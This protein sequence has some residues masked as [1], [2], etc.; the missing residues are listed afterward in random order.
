LSSNLGF[1]WDH[2]LFKEYCQ[3]LDIRTFAYFGKIDNEVL[4]DSLFYDKLFENRRYGIIYHKHSDFKDDEFVLRNSWENLLLNE[5]II[6]D[7]FFLNGG[8]WL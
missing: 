5:N 1:E 4:Y 2:K 7:K 8:A 6:L 3:E